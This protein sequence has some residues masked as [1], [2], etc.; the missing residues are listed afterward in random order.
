MTSCQRTV[1]FSTTE[2]VISVKTGTKLL[3]HKIRKPLT[4][5]PY[6]GLHTCTHKY[7]QYKV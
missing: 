3:W 2:T 5:L 1:N 6:W 7:K 4:R